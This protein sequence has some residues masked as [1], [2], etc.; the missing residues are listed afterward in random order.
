MLRR[1]GLTFALLFGLAT[2]AQ[3]SPTVVVGAW[4]G[5][6]GPQLTIPINVS[7]I[8]AADGV[9]TI[10]FIAEISGGPSGAGFQLNSPNFASVDIT[11]GTVFTADHQPVV[12]Q[13]S[14]RVDATH[15]ANDASAGGPDTWTPATNIAIK[16]KA[17]TA[18]NGTGIIT[19]NG[20]LATL[21]INTAGVLPGTYDLRLTGMVTGAGGG[22]TSSFAFASGSGTQ[23]F[24]NGTITITPEPASIVMGLFGAAALGAVAIRR[25]RARKSA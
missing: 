18:T 24:T 10:S 15:V 4:S 3:A 12:A 2:I 19:S 21:V 6:A 25:S 23:S 8:T 7:G 22:S 5:P 13:F 1:V 9:N 11:T 14:H 17:G 16:T 20:L